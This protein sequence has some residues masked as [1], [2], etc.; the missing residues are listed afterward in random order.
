M[1]VT[2]SPKAMLLAL[3]LAATSLPGAQ[4]ELET[5]LQAL[6]RLNY[7]PYNASLAFLNGVS[8]MYFIASCP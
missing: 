6:D 4:A 1:W 7:A 3:A 8:G 2:S 5:C